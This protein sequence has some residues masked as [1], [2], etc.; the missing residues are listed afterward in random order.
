MGS[1]SF[2]EINEEGDKYWKNKDGKLHR[3]DGPAVERLNGYKAWY[4][5]GLRHRLDG[6]AR[7]LEIGARHWYQNG[8]LH[9][10]DGPAVMCDNG[11]KGWYKNGCY[12][13][14]KD[15]FFNHLTSKEKEIALF[16]KDFLNG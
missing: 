14:N 13:K 8:E 4:K 11:Y 5:N 16:S 7:E 6:P 12:F 3:L 2:M 10:L 9:R 1:E 15:I